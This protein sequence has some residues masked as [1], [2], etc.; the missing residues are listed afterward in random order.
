MQHLEKI[1]DAIKEEGNK[2]GKTREV[3]KICMKQR[4]PSEN[5]TCFI[6][7]I[8]RGLK[9]LGYLENSELVAITVKLTWP[10]NLIMIEKMSLAK[11]IEDL[12]SKTKMHEEIRQRLETA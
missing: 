9:G 8:S 11:S 4:L 5:A 2:V 7:E 3:L 10:G 12:I 6:D 1:E